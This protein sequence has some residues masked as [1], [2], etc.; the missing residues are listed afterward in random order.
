MSIEVY[1][2]NLAI[3]I[4]LFFVL[5]SQLRKVI[6]NSSVRALLTWA[7]TI[8]LTPVIYIGV[9]A[10]V[11]FAFLNREQD[12]DAAEK[13]NGVAI[14]SSGEQV[15]SYAAID[16]ASLVFEMDSLLRQT[17]LPKDFRYI[18]TVEQAG[19][20]DSG[21]RKWYF[22]KNFELDRITY[23]WA[24]ER[25]SGHG[26]YF[27]DHGQLV[28]QVDS[29]REEGHKESYV[30]YHRL[31]NKAKGIQQDI[32]LTTNSDNIEVVKS[33]AIKVLSDNDFL[34]AEKRIQ[35]EISEGLLQI[36]EMRDSSKTAGDKITIIKS[37]TVKYTEGPY[38]ETT[39]FLMD[40]ALFDAIINMAF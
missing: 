7:G 30:R 17:D 38:Q 11:F 15:D 8:I 20:E 18:L 13:G 3:A 16:T 24:G 23:E 37:N 25:F 32:F 26:I 31:L 35:K 5:R 22:N 34:S 29:T 33:K 2:I 27:L 6:D 40:R 4:I 10:L 9:V 19:F 21:T 14:P 28:A 1:I 12:S 39:T 36:K